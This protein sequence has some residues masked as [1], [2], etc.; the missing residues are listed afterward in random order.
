MINK[1]NLEKIEFLSSLLKQR[2]ID[3]EDFLYEL[4]EL[5]SIDDINVIEENESLVIETPLYKVLISKLKTE[6]KF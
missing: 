1:V 3:R 4:E 2:K 6:I 5:L